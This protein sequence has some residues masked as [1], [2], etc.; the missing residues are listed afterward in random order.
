MIVQW[1]ENVWTLACAGIMSFLRERIARA[2]K[3]PVALTRRFLPQG[4]MSGSWSRIRESRAWRLQ[5]QIALLAL[6]LTGVLRYPPPARAQQ[7]FDSG[8]NGSDGALNLTTPGTVEFDPTTFNPPLDPDGD[9]VYHFTTITIAAGVTVHLLVRKVNGPVFW[10]ASGAVQIDGAIDLNGE[11]GTSIGST[12][13]S[14]LRAMPG[15]GGYA[16]GIAA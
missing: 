1:K 6:F 7:F 15:S 16:G 12:F 4:C 13:E 14:R 8:S 2:D 10:L 9:N 11:N 5:L 3:P